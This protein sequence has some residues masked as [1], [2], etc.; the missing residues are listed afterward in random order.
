MQLEAKIIED[1]VFFLGGGLAEVFF[2]GGGREEV[3]YK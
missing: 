2:C 1:N 3:G